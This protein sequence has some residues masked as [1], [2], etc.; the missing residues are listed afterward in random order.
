MAAAERALSASVRGRGLSGSTARG[1][2]AVLVDVPV[3]SATQAQLWRPAVPPRPPPRR[4]SAQSAPGLPSVFSL[5]ALYA[6]R[7]DSETRS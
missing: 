6:M 1:L 3:A 7:R 5:Y 2:S 4:R